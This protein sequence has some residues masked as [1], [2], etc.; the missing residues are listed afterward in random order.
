[1]EPDPL[2]AA[3]NGAP[4]NDVE[5]DNS[6]DAVTELMR[7][8]ETLNAV[9]KAIPPKEAEDVMKIINDR[10]RRVEEFE[11][12]IDRRL[13]CWSVQL[14]DILDHL[15]ECVD[16]QCD[17]ELQKRKE[18]VGKLRGQ[19]ANINDVWQ[20]LDLVSASFETVRDTVGS[21]SKRQSRSAKDLRR[22]MTVLTEK[23]PS[24]EDRVSDSSNESDVNRMVD[25]FIDA[26]RRDQERETVQNLKGQ[27]DDYYKCLETKLGILKQA[28]SGAKRRR[29]R[30]VYDND[31]SGSSPKKVKNEEK[32]DASFEPARSANPPSLNFWKDRRY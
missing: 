5:T 8:A 30:E 25:R 11:K 24:G 9:L 17:L 21:A 2:T 22:L 29:I 1:M 19:I 4:A 28:A 26:H 14:K 3:P 23:W 32:V 13:E 12:S 15:S 31:E 27:V 7:E 18:D 10:G 6:A 20:K 16:G